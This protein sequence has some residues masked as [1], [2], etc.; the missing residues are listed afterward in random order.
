MSRGKFRALCVDWADDYTM[1]TSARIVASDSFFTNLDAYS[2]DVWN[3]TWVI[4]GATLDQYTFGVE[5]QAWATNP[6]R[7]LG[8]AGLQDTLTMNRTAGMLLPDDDNALY[9]SVPA[10]MAAAGSIPTAAYS[11]W[12]GPLGKFGRCLSPSC[13]QCVGINRDRYGGLGNDTSGS[14]L[15]GAVDTAKYRG[16]LT[17]IRASDLYLQ[18]TKALG[19]PPVA[20]QGWGFELSSITVCAKHWRQQPE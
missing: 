13:R 10:A 4:G 2:G 12:L 19:L 1:S 20:S 5:N 17:S 7:S 15:F 6:Q 18:N 3:D 16:P 11:L 14:I 8:M 9:P